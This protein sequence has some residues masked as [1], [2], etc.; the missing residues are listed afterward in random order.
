LPE[1]QLLPQ[2]VRPLATIESVGIDDSERLVRSIARITGLPVGPPQPVVRQ[3]QE[4]FFAMVDALERIPSLLTE[5]DRESLVSLLPQ[6]IAGA[7]TYSGRRRSFMINL[8]NVCRDYP[9]GLT[10]LID[11]LRYAN[12]DECLPLRHLQ[13]LAAQFM[14]VEGD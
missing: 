4:L 3:A 1:P 14:A 11:I 5:N 12:G 8:L 13:Q 9:G 7:V 2:N 6:A 10:R